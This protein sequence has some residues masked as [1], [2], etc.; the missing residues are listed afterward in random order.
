MK[1][2]LDEFSTSREVEWNFHVYLSE[3]SK[4]TLGVGMVI[5]LDPL[6]ELGLIINCEAKVV[7]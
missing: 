7:K 1:F 4:E 6:C 3:M 2:K 5:G